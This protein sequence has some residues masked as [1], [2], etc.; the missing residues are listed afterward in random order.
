MAAGT[1]IGQRSGHW[2]GRRSAAARSSAWSTICWT[3]PKSAGMDAHRSVRLHAGVHVTSSNAL[4]TRS[5][6]KYVNGDAR[7]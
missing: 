1:A 3:S 4:S 2:S 5:A 7:S 6:A